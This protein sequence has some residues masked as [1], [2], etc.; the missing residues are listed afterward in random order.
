MSRPLLICRP[1]P[2]A[3]ATAARARQMGIEP[4]VHPL[5]AVEPLPWDAPD[6]A[7]VDALM[8]TSANTLR[9][10]GEAL[11]RYR[12]LPVFAVGEATG[13]AAVEAGFADVTIAGPD[14]PATLDRIA[15]AGHRHVFHP[16]GEDV[17]PAEAPGLEI[18]RRA[19]YR[20][21]ETEDSGRLET[22][23]DRRPVVLVH[24]PRA[25]ARIAGLVAPEAR[26]P[27]SLIA[28]SPAAR[29][30]A[31]TGWEQAVAADAPKDSAMLALARHLCL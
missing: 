24:S 18:V 26:G 31:G 11:A 13:T 17:R 25:G 19:V 29:D 22:L 16:G 8:L 1:R 23:L 4:L 28:I 12:R 20:A 27:L 9:H 10:G 6:P 3:D 14:A 2:G 7:L 15:R 30:A 21:V 5:F